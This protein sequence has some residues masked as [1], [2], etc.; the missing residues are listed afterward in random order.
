MINEEILS[1]DHDEIMENIKGKTQHMLTLQRVYVDYLND[2]EATLET[3]Y[4]YSLSKNGTFNVLENT[5]E[6]D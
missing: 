2:I 6:D 3:W 5:D 1:T 4:N